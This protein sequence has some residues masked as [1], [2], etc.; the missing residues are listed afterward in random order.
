MKTSQP[1][2]T[3]C[4]GNLPVERTAAKA[5]FT[6]LLAVTLPLL[7]SG[8]LVIPLTGLMDETDYSEQ[9]IEKGD[10]LFAGKLAVIELSGVLSS[11]AGGFLFTSTDNSVSGLRAQ[12]DLA[13][14]DS[15]VLGVLL[16]ISS[17][18]GEVTACDNLYHEIKKFRAETGKPIVAYIENIGA[19]GGLYAAMGADAVMSHPTA[20]VGSIGVIM[21][22][23]DLSRAIAAFGVEMDPIKS[24]K[25]KDLNSPWRSITKDE[26]QVLQKL[27]D[28][29]FQRFVDVVDSGRKKLDREKVLALADGR[30]FSG[31]EA[32][33]EGLV[34]KTGYIEDAVSELTSRLDGAQRKP[35]LIRYT[36][37]A[38]KGANI[39]TRGG[40]KTAGENS[41][42]LRLD[43]FNS[44]AGLYYL[45]KPSL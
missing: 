3:T 13:A 26:R 45:W 39:Y 19:S 16:K 36:R 10:G 18:G 38:G 25:M 15:G 29:M 21:Q 33:R 27:V 44:S 37:N 40:A 8:C 31:V 35:T 7:C 17:P 24:G 2:H 30:V 9:V 14:A 41:I 23:M 28:D 11:E 6:L 34:D 22:S 43:G 5:L 32:A 20:I 12:L 42:T 1:R 4:P